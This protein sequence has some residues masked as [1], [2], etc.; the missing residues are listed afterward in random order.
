VSNHILWTHQSICPV[1][2]P[3]GKSLHHLCWLLVT[4]IISVI[5]TAAE[6]GSTVSIQAVPADRHCTRTSPTPLSLSWS[7]GCGSVSADNLRRTFVHLYW[8]MEQNAWFSQRHLFLLHYLRTALR[9]F[10]SH[11]TDTFTESLVYTLLCNST[12]YL[13]YLLMLVFCWHC[14][15]YSYRVW[16][17]GM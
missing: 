2:G 16:W 13:L 6:Y 9:H 7:A 3:P 11:N 1:Y 12:L 15:Y 10:S 8:H 4:V 14:G 17:C 5:N